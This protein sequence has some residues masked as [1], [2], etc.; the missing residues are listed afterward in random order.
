M[1]DGVRI[2]AAQVGE[3]GQQIR[4][5]AD[6]YFA[7]AVD[8]G[9]DLHRQGVVFG[10]QYPGGAVVQAKQ[11]YAEALAIL[12]ANLRNYQLGAE[13][14]AE[15]AQRIAQE[16]ANVD[17]SSAQTQDAIQ[18]VLS[19]AASAVAARYGVA[20]NPAQSATQ[21]PSAPPSSSP[22]G[23]QQTGGHT[24]YAGGML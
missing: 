19:E 24:K 17:R 23:D 11:Q 15:V 2:D 20:V 6:T 18:R 14:Y 13:M 22:A 1:T 9:Q 5:D 3:T 8:H 12:D 21:A 10:S 4:R 7:S 16:F